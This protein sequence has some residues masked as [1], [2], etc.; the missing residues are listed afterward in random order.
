L[1]ECESP[2]RWASPRPPQH[3]TIADHPSGPLHQD[4]VIDGRMIPLDV[5]LHRPWA[6]F[7]E[8]QCPPH[9]G[10]RAL[11][12][13]T[14]VAVLN[15]AQ[16]EQRLDHP[17]KRVMH[18]PVTKRRGGDRAFLGIGDAEVMMRA[19]P[20]APLSQFPLQP[21]DLALPVAEESC[22]RRFTPLAAHRLPRRLGDVFDGDNLLPEPLVLR[23]V[24]LFLP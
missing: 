8:L 22:P 16:F 23:Y 5:A 4:V 11:A 1:V 20:V 9:P 7:R 24:S 15:E 19:R 18:H 3:G 21:D 2:A 13:A 12:F 17:H 10:V 6:P 14:S